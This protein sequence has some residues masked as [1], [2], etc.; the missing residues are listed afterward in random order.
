MALKR[1]FLTGTLFAYAKVEFVNYSKEEPIQIQFQIFEKDSANPSYLKKI[2]TAQTFLA[3]P[4]DLA[5]P[6]NIDTLTEA[7]NNVL[8]AA[9]LWIKAK[10]DLFRDFEDA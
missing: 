2:G 4:T 1:N 10:I 5:S 6:F 7:G 9:Y 3:D 8:K